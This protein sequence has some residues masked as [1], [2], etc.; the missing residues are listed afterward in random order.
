MKQSIEESKAK[1]E[2]FFKP[3]KRNKLHHHLGMTRYAT[4]IGKWWKEERKAAEV[5]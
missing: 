1:G 5:G 4:K 2:K 3:V